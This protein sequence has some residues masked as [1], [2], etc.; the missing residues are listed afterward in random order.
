MPSEVKSLLYLYN[1]MS[2]LE[3]ILLLKELQKYYINFA[4]IAFLN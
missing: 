2:S 1:W 3:G 4:D